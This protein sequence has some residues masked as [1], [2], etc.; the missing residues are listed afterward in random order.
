MYTSGKL[1][2]ELS[3][4]VMPWGG[5]LVCFTSWLAKEGKYMFKKNENGQKINYIAAVVTGLAAFALSLLWYSPLL[6]GNIWMALRNA[7]VHPLP[8][9][10]FIFAPLREIITAFLLTHLIVRWELTIGKTLSALDSF[11]GFPFISCN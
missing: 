9:W 7:P 8:G 11:Y 5:G 6:F 4:F 2:R 10:T 1:F 3:C